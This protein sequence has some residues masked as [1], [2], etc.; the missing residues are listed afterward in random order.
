M[1]NLFSG[2]IVGLATGCCGG[3]NFSTRKFFIRLPK[4]YSDFDDTDSDIFCRTSVDWPLL[5]IDELLLV[6]TLEEPEANLF[7]IKNELH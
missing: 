2:C 5:T 4:D 3:E 7:V 1:I 6:N